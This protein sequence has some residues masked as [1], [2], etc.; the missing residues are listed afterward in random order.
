MN[1]L[2]K[3]KNIFKNILCVCTYISVLCVCVCVCVKESL[4]SEVSDNPGITVRGNCVL[5]DVGGG[6]KL[7][8]TARTIYTLTSLDTSLGLEYTYLS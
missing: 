2:F 7:K 1:T 5:P 3:L 6:T 8:S 4:N